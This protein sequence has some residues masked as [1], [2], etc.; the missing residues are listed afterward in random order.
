MQINA[1]IRTARDKG[2]NTGWAVPANPTARGLEAP[3]SPV[4]PAGT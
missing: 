3:E 4:E 1:A 2:G